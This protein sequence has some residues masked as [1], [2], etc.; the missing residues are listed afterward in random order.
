MA[1]R[2]DALDPNRATNAANNFTETSQTNQNTQTNQTTTGSASRN[3]TSTTDETSKTD[4][5]IDTMSA[6]GRQAMTRLLAQ[7]AAGGTDEQRAIL[8]EQM[9]TLQGIRGDKE[10]Y[11]RETALGDAEGLMQT[12]LQR[13]M[14]EALPSILMAGQGAGTSGSAITALLSQDLATRA[15]GQAAGVGVDAVQGYGSILAQL[16]GQEVAATQGM[17]DQALAALMEA[18][19]IDAGSMKRGSQTTNSRSTTNARETTN[20]RESTTGSQRTTGTTVTN[21]TPNGQ[22]RR[23]DYNTGSRVTNR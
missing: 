1:S 11:S 16:T 12:M 19:G 15:A 4:L 13:S 20:S 2:Y 8:E 5:N 9:R 21:R 10:D 18:L 7:L 22:T 23:Q 17:E 14:E 6:Q 3:S